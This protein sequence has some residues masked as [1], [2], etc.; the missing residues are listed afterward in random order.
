[1]CL[2]CLVFRGA[3]LFLD[4]PVYFIVDHF[5]NRFE[6]NRLFVSIL[7]V[8]IVSTPFRGIRY[9]KYLIGVCIL[10]Y[11]NQSLHDVIS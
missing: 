2:D 8:Q 7:L 9:P 3:L 5:L 4:E 11:F 10:W 1:M 6:T